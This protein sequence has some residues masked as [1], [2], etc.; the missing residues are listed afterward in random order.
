M[1]KTPRILIS[2]V[3][4]G[5]DAAPYVRMSY[6]GFARSAPVPPSLVPTSKNYFL[7]DLRWSLE[8][9]ATNDPLNSTRANL[10]ADNIKKYTTLLIE[11]VLDTLDSPSNFIDSR[12]IIQLSDRL[13]DSALVTSSSDGANIVPL[14]QWDCLEDLTLWPS[15]CRPR[16]VAVIR[17]TSCF[18]LSDD[19]TPTVP[20]LLVQEGKPTRILAISARPAG[21]SDVPHRLITRTIYQVVQ[22]LESQPFRPE[23]SIARPGTI[24]R[25]EKTLQSYG[26][27]HFDILHIDVHG[28]ANEK[29]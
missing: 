28:T 4:H 11:L 23:F 19:G 29:R 18:N 8:D 14:M 21:D 20:R 1:T 16:A 10:V 3:P 22:S 26:A 12:I 2:S 13:R 27:G 7:R 15:H 25:L 17:T 24:E 6:R 9:F 5:P